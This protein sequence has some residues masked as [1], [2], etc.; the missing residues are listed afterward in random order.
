M[1]KSK[2][3]KILNGS[4]KRPVDIDDV[5]RL[6]AGI[7][8]EIYLDERDIETMD[9]IEKGLIDWSGDVPKK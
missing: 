8:Q 3:W 4:F 6:I 2:T 1:S 9:A 5:E 7:Q